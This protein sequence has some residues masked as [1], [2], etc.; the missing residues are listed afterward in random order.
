MSTAQPK[1]NGNKDLIGSLREKL[2]ATALPITPAQRQDLLAQLSS[3]LI[4]A[5]ATR[6]GP[7]ACF[8]LL[9]PVIEQRLQSLPLHNRITG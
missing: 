1:P 6:I 8:A 2:N 5:Q 3:E 7:A 9:T 4:E